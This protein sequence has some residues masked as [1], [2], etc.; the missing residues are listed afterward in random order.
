MV[1]SLTSPQRALPLWPRLN[2]LAHLTSHLANPLRTALNVG[3]F[4]LALSALCV[5]AAS[6]TDIARGKALYNQHCLTCHGDNPA[7]GP[8]QYAANRVDVLR[9][10]FQKVGQMGFFRTLLTDAEVEAIAAYVGEAVSARAAGAKDDRLVVEYYLPSTKHYFVSA[11]RAEQ[12]MIDSGAVGPW[13]RTGES[14]F[15]GGALQT[16]RFYGNT[17]INP[18]SKTIHGPSSHFFTLDSAECEGLIRLFNPRAAAWK[19]EGRDFLAD[20]PNAA[21]QCDAPQ[22]ALYRAYNNGVQ[23]G[24]DSNHRLTTN[25]AAID[26]LVAQGWVDEGVVMCVPS[27]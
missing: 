5:S 22:R 1:C 7:I 21:R 24:V 19:F 26:S 10:A 3:V 9:A 16:C 14:F 6:A 18:I 11:S 12:T 20:K 15:S 13:Q 25:R 27:M 17:E 2:R 23:R 8:P 4:S